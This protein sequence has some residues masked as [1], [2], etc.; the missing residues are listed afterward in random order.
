MIDTGYDDDRYII[1]IFFQV[2]LPINCVIIFIVTV[3]S[4]L[5]LFFL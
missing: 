4:G 3:I 1:F 5:H 2:V